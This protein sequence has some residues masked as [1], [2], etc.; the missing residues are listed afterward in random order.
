MDIQKFKS[1]LLTEGFCDMRYQDF[2]LTS[3]KGTKKEIDTVAVIKK[4]GGNVRVLTGGAFGTFC[5]TNPEDLSFAL[6][7][8]KFA[9]DMISGKKEF[10]HVEKNYSE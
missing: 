10:T 8:A 1:Q 5:F 9:S 6:K 4:S 2:T 7:E 3:I